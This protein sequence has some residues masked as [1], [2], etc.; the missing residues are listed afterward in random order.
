MSNQNLLTITATNYP[1]SILLGSNSYELRFQIINNS[2]KPEQFKF[3]FKMEGISGTIPMEFKEP[4]VLDSAKPYDL[5]IPIVPTVNGSAKLILQSNKYSE[6]KYTEL[7]WQTR[8]QVSSKFIKE[9]LSKSFVKFQDLT[10]GN[11]KIPKFKNGKALDVESAVKEYEKIYSESMDSGVKDAQLVDVAKSVFN[12]DPNFAFEVLK[13]VQDQSS[14]QQLLADFI[15]ALLEEDK[16]LAVA[17]LTILHDIPIKDELIQKMV[18]YFLEKDLN[19]AIQLCKN[20]TNTEIRDILL[21]DIFHFSYLK[22]FDDAMQLISIINDERLQVGLY[23]EM[24]KILLKTNPS[25]CTALLQNLIKKC[26]LLKETEI[27]SSLF[28]IFAYIHNPQTTIDEISKLP[29]DLQNP[30]NKLTTKALREQKEEEKIRIEQIPVSS[31]YYAFN[32]MA[33]PSS[34]ISKV[35]ELGGTV[36]E[37][38]ISGIMDSVIGII[39]LFSFNFPVYPTIEQCYA[40]IKNEKGK[41]FYYLIIPLKNAD[42]QLYEVVQSIIKNL[43]VT[44]ASNVPHK[45]YLFNLDFI[46]YL[47]K[48]T[49]IVGDDPEENIVI[50]SI[51]KRVFKDQV[52]LI[53]DDG[54]FKDGKITEWIKS[55]LPPNKFKLVNLVLTYDFLNNHTMFKD[56]MNEF[57]R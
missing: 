48:P 50:Q 32:V 29:I 51:I 8:N 22:Q 44:H 25:K 37:N 55:I 9:V 42:D 28:I 39:N 38:L 52:S 35:S 16:D 33:K 12:S 20:V 17:K 7:V 21:R 1:N 24:I 41:S 43:F 18:A 10:K 4:I 14:I 34:V 49:I 23:Y 3:D 19:L 56:F 53:I 2:T 26:T 5:F 15:Y 27:L 45:M 36:S 57:V 40:E 54:L 47:S 6:V 30:V 11:R 13:M 46:P 31:L